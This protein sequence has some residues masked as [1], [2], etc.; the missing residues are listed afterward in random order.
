MLSVASTH[1][2]PTRKT[3]RRRRELLAVLRALGLVAGGLAAPAL[4]QGNT[5]T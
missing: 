4:G 2:R 1:T 5:V 3:V